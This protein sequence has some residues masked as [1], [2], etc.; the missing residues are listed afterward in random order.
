MKVT[1]LNST[2]ATVSGF[3]NVLHVSQLNEFL[4]PLDYLVTTLPHTEHTHNLLDAAALE[5]LPA[6][7]YIVNVGRGNVIDDAGLI[8]ALHDG[9]LAGAAL[10]VFDKEPIPEDSPLWNAPNLSITA[11]I[12]ALS[13]PSL[14]VPIFLDNYRRYSEN[15]P[16]AYVVDFEKG[17]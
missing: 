14:I 8:A 6:H 16:L 10:V 1:G 12:A 9:A 4:K 5:K 2:G 3:D 11:H 7:A 17:Y 15:Q 13:H